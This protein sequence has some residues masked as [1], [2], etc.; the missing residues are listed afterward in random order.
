MNLMDI[1]NNPNSII[2]GPPLSKKCNTNFVQEDIT[3][4]E[5]LNVDMSVKNMAYDVF[6]KNTGYTLFDLTKLTTLNTTNNATIINNTSFYVFITIFLVMALIL[7]VLMVTNVLN[8]IVGLHLL[9]LLSIIIYVMSILY[10]FN[11]IINTESAASNVDNAIVRN[12][13]LYE[14]SIALLPNSM[15]NI[16]KVVGN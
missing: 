13:A 8:T 16:N 9:L 14:Q 1:I 12:R 11:T 5:L 4:L 3:N 7:I 6:V 10:R 15:K 2:G